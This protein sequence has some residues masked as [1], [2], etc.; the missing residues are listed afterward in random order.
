MHR[1]TP[2]LCRI[3]FSLCLLIALLGGKAAY[4]DEN[5]ELQAVFDIFTLAD[6]DNAE[7]LKQLEQLYSTQNAETSTKVRLNTLRALYHLNAELGNTSAANGFLNAM[8][9]LALECNDKDALLMADV[10]LAFQLHQ[11]MK[12]EQ[13]LAQLN[14]LLA[15]LHTDASA[16]AR[17]RLYGALG[18]INYALGHYDTSLRFYLD[19]LRLTDQLPFRREQNRIFILEGLALLYIAMKDPEKSLAIVHEALALTPYSRAPKNYASL[20]ID[21]GVA[22]NMLGREE[23]ALDAYQRALKIARDSRLAEVEINCLLYITTYYLKH[24]QYKQAET[25]ARQ[26]LLR[27]EQFEDSGYIRNA[28]ASIGFALLGQ[29]KITQGIELVNEVITIATET[30]EKSDVEELLSQLAAVYEHVGMYKE[31]LAAVRKQQ[32]VNAEL[33]RSDRSKAVAAIQEQFQSEQKQKQIALLERDN[34]LKDAALQNHQLRQR[35]TMLIAVVIVVAGVFIFAL[36]RRVRQANQKLRTVNTQLEFHAERD[37]LT[38]LYNRRSFVEMM[39]NRQDHLKLDRRAADIDSPDCLVLLDIDHFKQINDTLGHAA[40]DVVLIEV[41]KRLRAVVRDSDMVLRW[42]G[43]E[44]LVFSPKSQHAQVVALVERVLYAIGEKRIHAGG[45]DIQVTVSAGFIAL[46]FSGVSESQLNW[47]KVL[48][49][50]DMA[51]YL[52]KVN[53]RNRAYGVSELLVAPDLALPILEQDLAAAIDADMV[54]LTEV[55]GPPRFEQTIFD[56]HT[57]KE[58]NELLAL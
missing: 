43:E 37:P 9:K 8:R 10:I 16:D 3:L 41:A 54:S 45:R 29:G 35:V 11:A 33:F 38:G 5:R 57:K 34:A 55:E 32:E 51:L 22:L 27:S 15:N 49:I 52:G 1:F 58:Q 17:F 7:A 13:A 31:A 14:Q 42:G 53:G 25:T 48:Q 40:G 4:A 28:K 30:G 2:S 18:N 24:H 19:V 56:K 46:P 50:A 39:K 26:A 21:E 12:P 6:S 44:F 47:E 20:L 23:Q 36:Y